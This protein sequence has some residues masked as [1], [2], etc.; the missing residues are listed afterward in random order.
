L[1][2]LRRRDLESFPPTTPSRLDKQ[3]SIVTSGA[4]DQT[5]SWVVLGTTV[6]RFLFRQPPPPKPLISWNDLSPLEGGPN[7]TISEG[8]SRQ[9][10]P[11][12]AAPAPQPS[13]R[14][15]NVPQFIFP[16]TVPLVLNACAS[17][18]SIHNSCVALPERAIPSQELMS[19]VGNTP[20]SIALIAYGIN[21]LWD[22]TWA[23][24]FPEPDF[25]YY[26]GTPASLEDIA[27]LRQG[28]RETHHRLWPLR[29]PWFYRDALGSIEETLSRTLK[30]DGKI[31]TAKMSDL[32]L[33]LEALKE[34]ED[35]NL[36]RYVAF[37]KLSLPQTEALQLKHS[38]YGLD[39][40]FQ[41]L[42]HKQNLDSWLVDGTR[43]RLS[44]FQR[45]LE[46]LEKQPA[47]KLYSTIKKEFDS[48]SKTLQER[49][50]IEFPSTY[51]LYLNWIEM[52]QQRLREIRYQRK[53]E[54]KQIKQEKFRQTSF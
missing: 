25:E 54:E 29:D 46:A 22:S 49:H 44:H 47:K 23:S 40:A 6:Y 51:T 34:D 4:A 10:E 3:D 21:C 50:A 33:D 1:P 7:M 41:D 35:L 15:P 48:F 9:V 2:T 20:V 11:L 24:L 28:I 19:Q 45:Q 17:G 5:P 12:G 37:R 18:S 32:K 36:E 26:E 13:F 38:I 53:L 16:G 8:S 30:K 31:S 27:S 43:R 42:V 39:D 52:M 14:N